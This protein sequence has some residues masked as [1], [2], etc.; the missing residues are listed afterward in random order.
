MTRGAKKGSIPWNKGK[1]GV[2]PSHA[3]FQK[4]HGKL[5]DNESYEKAREKLSISLRKWFSGKDVKQ[6]KSNA[7]KGEK[8]GY[9]AFHEWLRVNF[10]SAD[11][12]EMPGCTYP[13]KNRA[14][15]VIYKPKGFHWSLIH[16]NEHGHFRENYWMLCH[17][18]HAL[19]DRI[20][21]KK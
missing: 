15:R 5:R 3:G 11:K 21:H 10:G 8:A 2:M 9:F 20:G 7:W 4:G 18:C 6:E 19:Y 14:Q 1:S 17:S 13:R 16:G 12:C